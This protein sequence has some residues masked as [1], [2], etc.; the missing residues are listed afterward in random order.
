MQFAEDYKKGDIY[1]LG[2]YQLEAEEMITFATQYD[3]QPYHLSEEEGAKSPF[4]GLIASGWNIAGI[5][6][7]LYVTHMLDGAKVFGSPGVDEVRFKQPVRPGQILEG[8]V[9][10]LDR[11]PSFS[12]KSIMIIRKYGTLS[13]A[14]DD[15]PVFSLILNSRFAKRTYY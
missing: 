2:S 4:N 6:M 12:D 8:K 1:Y 10:I 14:G 15:R 13:V 7:K 11:L 9:E 5:W 3:P